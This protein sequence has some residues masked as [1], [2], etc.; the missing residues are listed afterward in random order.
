MSAIS[1]AVQSQFSKS[2]LPVKKQL[3]EKL[4]IDPA[5]LK[6]DQLESEPLGLGKRVRLPLAAIMFCIGV[7]ATLAWQSRGDVARKAIAGA[8]PRLDWLA[9]Q[10]IPVT[11]TAPDIIAPAASAA[12]SPD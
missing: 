12:P 7:A 10:A 11:Q 3:V 8:V 9:P 4:A 6:N 2:S 1:S 5:N